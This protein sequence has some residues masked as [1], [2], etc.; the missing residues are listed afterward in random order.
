[1]QSSQPETQRSRRNLSQPGTLGPGS[2]RCAR[3]EGVPL[4]V[5]RRNAGAARAE[6]G[7]GARTR[8]GAAGAPSG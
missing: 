1:M 2:P 4:G 5:G 6:A 3:A 8:G 7:R